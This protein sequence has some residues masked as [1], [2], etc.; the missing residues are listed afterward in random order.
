MFRLIPSF[1]FSYHIINPISPVSCPSRLIP[2]PSSIYST[3][4][5]LF[6]FLLCIL[7]QLLRTRKEV[8]KADFRAFAIIALFRFP[9][10]AEKRR[11]ASCQHLNPVFNSRLFLWIAGAIRV[12]IASE[13]LETSLDFSS[14]PCCFALR[15][16][17]N[18]K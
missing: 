14:V 4:H 1:L 5:S 11:L 3:I 12:S 10:P 8:S 7:S 9:L 16:P 18:R 13:E 2:P 17:Y 6:T 15:S